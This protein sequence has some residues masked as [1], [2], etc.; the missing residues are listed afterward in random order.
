MVKDAF[1]EWDRM[2]TLYTPCRPRFPWFSRNSNCFVS[3]LQVAPLWRLLFEL[4]YYIEYG[5]IDDV[6]VKSCNE[7]STGMLLKC[8]ALLVS[9]LF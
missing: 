8:F 7:L 6:A 5:V 2:D 9:C 1:K 3:Y 4:L